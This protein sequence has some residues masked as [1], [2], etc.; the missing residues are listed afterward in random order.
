MSDPRR[1]TAFLSARVEG[2]QRDAI[3]AVAE[4]VEISVSRFVAEQLKEPALRELVRHEK[5]RRAALEQLREEAA[6][7]EP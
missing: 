4:R 3:E 5:T 2:W 6:G 1:R 7:G